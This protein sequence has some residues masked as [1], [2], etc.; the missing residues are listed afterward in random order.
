MRAARVGVALASLPLV[1]L[2]G[3]TN[4]EAGQAKPGAAVGTG[5]DPSSSASPTSMR[6]KEIKIDGLD[7]CKALSPA[8]EEQLG[9]EATNR[10]DIDAGKTGKLAPTCRFRHD[11]TPNYSYNLSLVSDRG[12]DY[13]DPKKSNLD[14][15][16]LK[17]GEFPAVQLKLKGTSQGDCVVAIDVAQGQQLYMQFLPISRVYSQEQMCENAKTGAELALATVQTLR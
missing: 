2:A 7:P 8:Q 6:P 4:S 9:I 5:S 1:V 10:S 13:W 16:T 15:N 12:I 14:V 17:V 11:T 3:C